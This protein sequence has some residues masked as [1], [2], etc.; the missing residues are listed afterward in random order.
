MR[1]RAS[2]DRQKS[3]VAAILASASSASRG[4][5]SPSAHVMQT[6]ARSPSFRTCLPRTRFPSIPSARLDR[7]PNVCPAPVASAAW[8][9]PSGIV[10]SAGVR[11]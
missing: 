10:H 3:V 11:P 7:S 5:A 2:H 1:A 8:T 4:A 9:S 6:Y